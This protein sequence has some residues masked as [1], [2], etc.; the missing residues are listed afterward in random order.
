MT[1][2]PTRA[3]LRQAEQPNQL[4]YFPTHVVLEGDDCR[5]RFPVTSIDTVLRELL[6]VREVIT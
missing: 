6:K 5:G 2:K 4:G 3:R 1:K